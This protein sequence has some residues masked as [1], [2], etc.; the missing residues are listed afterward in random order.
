[1]RT[2]VEN[3]RT[4]ARFIHPGW[5][6]C[7]YAARAVKP[8]KAFVLGALLSL[9]NC[10]TSASPEEP[11]DVSSVAFPKG[12]LW[13]GA[14]AGF[15]VEKGLSDTDWGIFSGLPGTIQKGAKADDGPDA[16]AHIDQDVASMQAAGFNAYRFSIEMARVYPD[17]KS[18]DDD[19]PSADG[20]AAYDAL[21]A[22][23]KAAN[24][25]P[26]VTLH[27][28]VWPSYLSNPTKKKEPQGWERSDVTPVFTAWCERMGKRFGSRTDLWVTINEPNVEAAVGYLAGK[29]SPGVVDVER[30]ATVMRN[31][32]EAHARCFDALHATDTEDSDGDGKAALVGIAQHQRV[33]EPAD[34][35]NEEDVREAA[36]ARYVWN[37]WIMESIVN[38]KVDDDFD[39][40][41]E[42]TEPLRVGRA[43]FFG[44]NYYGVSR[45]AAAGLRVKY[46][47]AIPLQLDL[48][49]ERPKTDNG[50]DIHPAGFAT[51]LDEA[52]G[53]GLP[54]YITE[55]G[56]A[57]ATDVNRSRFIAEHLFEL[58][59]S[60]ARGADV[61]GYLHWSL[62]D[63]FEWAAGFCPRF[64][65]YRVA[66]EDP[67]R[68]RTA[69]KAVPLLQ[70]VAT[71]NVLDQATIAAL[72]SYQSKPF[73]CASY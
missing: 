51:V 71:S 15:Q 16:L 70:A 5:A 8:T 11:T 6:S 34:P 26:M 50:W 12:M 35:T 20:L 23:L 24:I 14:T 65:L 54:I 4:S 2:R 55:N 53:Y 61:R 57:D 72:P 32:V 18:F 52:I 1:M 37:L 59:K 28:F 44:L 36:H 45:V 25:T 3:A 73:P 40:T 21:F 67:Q 31:Q 68:Q 64:G 13:G 19:T 10:T 22:A 62:M 69:T 39:G 56:I 27:H 43:D 63:N 42:K 33:Y 60:Q 30:A 17:R 38:G 46:L 9:A 58:G 41:P 29:F 7:G 48:P 47:G 49:T 66:F